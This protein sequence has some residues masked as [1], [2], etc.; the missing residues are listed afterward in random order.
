M[1]YKILTTTECTAPILAH[2]NIA[3]TSSNTIG[4]YSA[5]I[6]PFWTPKKEND[7]YEID[8]L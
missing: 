4:I 1:I 5:T 8:R 3:T 7:L 2:A 6:S